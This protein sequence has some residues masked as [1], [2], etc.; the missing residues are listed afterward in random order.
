LV[1]LDGDAEEIRRNREEAEREARAVA[2]EVTEFAEN[3]A[4]DWRTEDDAG[5]WSKEFPGSAVVLGA[6]EPERLVTLV[7]EWSRRPLEAA[8]EALEW[9]VCRD[10]GWRTPERI[11]AEGCEILPNPKRFARSGRACSRRR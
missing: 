8:L 6:L 4:Y 10:H 2:M 3:E 1:E 9:V 11:R 7:E 5:R